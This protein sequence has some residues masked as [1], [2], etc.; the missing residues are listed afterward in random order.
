M[1]K[2]WLLFVGLIVVVTCQAQS[3]NYDEAMR[4]MKVKDFDKAIDY[5]SR[6]LK[7]N[8]KSGRAFFFRAVLYRA[9]EQNEMA[10]SDIT[11]A[12]KYLPKDN[13]EWIA[14][15]YLVRGKIYSNINNNEKALKNFNN[16]IKLTPGMVDGYMDRA[17][18]FL[19]LGHFQ[20]AESDYRKVISLEEGNV[21]AWTGLGC[22]YLLQGN[23]CEAE[24]TLNQVIKLDPENIEGY[25]FRGITYFDS[26]R[27]D[28][29][30]EDLFQ[31]LIMD[32]SDWDV[33]K[34]FI[35]YAAKNYPLALSK[36]NQQIT[37]N[38]ENDLWY[39][40]R[41]RVLENKNDLI[42]AISDYTKVMELTDI[43]SRP[44]L[45]SFRAL[46]YLNAGLYEKAISDFSD[47][48][49]LD[50]TITILFGYRGS[51]K[52]LTGDYKGA[53]EDFTKA[54][55]NDPNQDGFLY[56]RGWAR[57]CLAD[58][59]GALNDYNDAI[60]FNNTDANYYLNRGR[61]LEK[62]MNK[63]NQAIKDFQNIVK[64]D[65][66]ILYKDNCRQYALYYLGR[67]DESIAWQKKILDQYPT[68]GNYYE[69]A[70]LYSLMNKQP[71]A[72]NCLTKALEQGYRDF[73]HLSDDEYLDN[74]RGSQEF[75][76][77]VEKW[78]KVHQESIN[79]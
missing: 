31:C 47:A 78:Q 53:V 59:T 36:V 54:L 52:R 45:L 27:Y 11:N 9:K 44:T 50:S 16:A 63:R 34:L 21:R 66:V 43:E 39:F 3:N 58:Y 2:F 67:N 64:I 40:I 65:T 18:F 8:P 73:I 1:K 46:C 79:K 75:K 72:L 71:E 61:L 19:D 14:N 22:N 29:A 13:K 55:A 7:D 38:P 10:L 20:Q 32:Q 26:D 28:E 12:I 4:A 15:A 41:A 6:D 69:A 17:H 49:S 62:R 23:Y 35:E 56:G 57:E 77:L 5:L 48:L 70:R 37:L 25:Y 24:K 68:H 30:I 33:R 42:P 74:I 76:V 60:S 51:A